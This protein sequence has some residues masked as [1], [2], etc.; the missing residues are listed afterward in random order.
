LQTI[1]KL[2]L[3]FRCYRGLDFSD[4][5]LDIARQKFSGKTNI[6]FEKRDLTDL[7]NMNEKFDI[8]IC[9]WVISHLPDPVFFVN[10]AQKF[11]NKNGK[12]F[13]VFFGK[14][15]KWIN[16]WLEPLAKYLFMSKPI[17]NDKITQFKNVTNRHLYAFGITDCL[18][19]KMPI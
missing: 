13:L 14:P 1:I 12:M 5:M 19:I 2:D 4:N 9:T 11:L 18:E 7:S 16:F 6:Q 8:I 15:Q 10:Q 3:P 17:E